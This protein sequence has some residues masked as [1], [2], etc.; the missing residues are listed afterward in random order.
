[1]WSVLI[2]SVC[3]HTD[4]N[5]CVRSKLIDVTCRIVSLC[6]YDVSHSCAVV[7]GWLQTSSRH[8]HALCW[9][10]RKQHLTK[11]LYS[12]ECQWYMVSGWLNSN[13]TV[14]IV[15]INWANNCI[16]IET[17]RIGVRIAQAFARMFLLTVT[18]VQGP[19]NVNVHAV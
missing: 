4:D 8:A 1:V 16:V 13:E 5:I 19:T 6:E 12:P 7:F 2:C 9:R 11:S 18:L 10:L 17:N 14:K 15:W 3:G